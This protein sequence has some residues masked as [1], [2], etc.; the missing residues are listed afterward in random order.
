[1]E[2]ALLARGVGAAAAAEASALLS[3]SGC[4]ADAAAEAVRAC[5]AGRCCWR[6]LFSTRY[7]G[8]AYYHN[9]DGDATTWD[10]PPSHALWTGR[11]DAAA[12]DCD[13]AHVAAVASAVRALH[14]AAGS[15][16]FEARDTAR[17][18]LSAAVTALPGAR[19]RTLRPGNA[20]LQARLLRHA[21]AAEALLLAAGFR[22]ESGED[23]EPRLRLPQEAPS[24]PLRCA[25]ARLEAACRLEDDSSSAANADSA[26][27]SA[28]PEEAAMRRYQRVVHRCACCGR[29]INDGSERAWTG[30]HDAPRGEFRYSCETCASA[31]TAASLCEACADAYGAGKQGV[32]A[33]GHALAPHAPVSSRLAAAGASGDGAASAANPWGTFGAA[34][35]ARSRE[36]LKDRTGL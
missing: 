2:A 30:R 8:R 16:W 12:F 7:G 17:A 24:G 22:R 5:A 21:P 28:T 6:E 35:S 31:G 13:V 29:S 34:V 15:A 25:V 27:A 26:S 9:R 19:E 33:Q 10:E 23:G 1:M 32:H 4:S 36:R 3:P 20:A 14:F 18:L 11:C